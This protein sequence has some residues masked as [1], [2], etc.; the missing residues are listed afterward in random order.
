MSHGKRGW[1]A[2]VLLAVMLSLMAWPTLG[3]EAEPEVVTYRTPARKAEA[4]QPTLR[5][6]TLNVA[7]GRGTGRHQALTRKRTHMANLDAVAA[8]LMRL[9]PDVVA[10]QEA[11]GPSLWSGRFSHIDYLA[12]KAEFAC[13]IR[14]EHVKRARNSYGTALLSMLPLENPKSVC[15]A[16]SPPTPTKGFV[17]ATVA[18]PGDPKVKLDVA[19]VHLDFARNS[20]RLRQVAQLIEALEGR[21]H[22]LVVM[23]DFNCQWA[24]DGSPLPKLAKALELDAH[25]PKAEGMTTFPKLKRRLDWIL[26]SPRLVFVRYE[27]VPD[28]VSD[29]LGV[30][31]EI[32]LAKQ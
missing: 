24:D 16:P 13:S 10:L 9:E 14:G 22:P 3:G 28:R 1:H 20:V 21:G 19:S 4:P 30:V 8:L 23:G 17:V 11:D 2:A 12:G 18:W 27:N 26:I 5:V 29:H 6:V 7:H 31:C 32:G 25:K 15:F